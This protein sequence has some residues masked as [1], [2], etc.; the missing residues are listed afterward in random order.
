MPKEKIISFIVALIMVIAPLGAIFVVGS[1]VGGVAIGGAATISNLPVTC[2]VPLNIFDSWNYFEKYLVGSDCSGECEVA[3]SGGDNSALAASKIEYVQTIIGTGKAMKVPPPGIVAAL[4]TALVE[5]ELKNYANDGVYDVIKNN[6]DSSLGSPSDAANILSFAQ[7]S[8]AYPHDAV[9]SDA[10]SVGLFQQQAWWGTVG[11]STWQNDPEGT[12]K[13][14]MDPTFQA[15]KFYNSLLKIPDWQSLSGGDIAQTVQSS[16]RPLAYAL[17]LPEAN[18][19]YNKYSDTA[20][21]VTLYDLG[22]SAAP[23]PSSSSS[24]SSNSNISSPVSSCGGTGA[25][26]IPLAKSASYVITAPFGDTIFHPT[27]HAGLDI[28]CQM[29]ATVSSPVTGTVVMAMNGNPSGTGDPA[30]YV[31]VR[32]SDG[33]VFWLWH[34]RAATVKAGQQVTGGQPI[35]ECGSTGN[36]SGPHLHIQAQVENSTNAQIKAL[37]VEE[38]INPGEMGVPESDSVRDPALV[39]DVLGVNIC[40]P[41]VAD[42]KKAPSGSPLP[43]SAKQC[44]PPN[45]WTK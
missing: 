29:G 37:P 7:R 11:A 41:Y 26:S 17:R 39:L 16:A 43:E 36:S 33:T 22:A 27:P 15:Q 10:T 21:N 5:S 20:K 38:G 42:R 8:L 35:G 3:T 9:G 18:A 6:A 19:L 44:W 31:K 4:S 2:K 14:L 34:L 45:E 40:P 32:T 28:A 24:K 30:G 1:V 23:A 25:T 13:R 12:M